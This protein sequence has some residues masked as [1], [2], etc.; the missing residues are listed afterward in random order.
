MDENEIS[1]IL[2][3]SKKIMEIEG[4]TISKELEAQGRK[5]L[6]GELDINDYVNSCKQKAKGYASEI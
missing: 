3:N 5:I 6:T 2:S 4:F 1:Q